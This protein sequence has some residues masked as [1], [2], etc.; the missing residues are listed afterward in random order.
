MSQ[1]NIKKW[2]KPGLYTTLDK[3]S[4]VLLGFINFFILSRILTKSDFGVWVLFTGL[5]SVLETLREG[6]IKQPFIAL[7]PTEGEDRDQIGSTALWL[8]W[9]YSIAVSLLLFFGGTYLELFWDAS[10]LGVLL[11]IYA[12]VNLI[13]VPFSHYEYLQQSMLDFKGI[14]I[15]HFSRSLIPTVFILV[16]IS[17]DNSLSLPKLA[18]SVLAGNLMGAIL[19][20]YWG[21]RYKHNLIRIAWSEVKT[22]LAFGR[23]SLGTNM[24]SLSI[25]NMDS[26]MLGKLL[27]TASVASYNPAIRIANLVE[28][29]TLTIANLVF[30][31]MAQH[32]RAQDVTQANELYSR[33]VGLLLT[34]MIPVSLVMFLF[35][36][37]IVYLIAGRNYLDSGYLLKIT[38]FYTLF[39]PFGRQFGILLDATRKPH[40]NFYVVLATAIVGSVT[41]Y[42]FILRWGVMGAAYGTLVTYL[43][44]FL[45]QQWWLYKNFKVSTLAVF[46]SVPGF[47]SYILNLILK[48]GIKK[49]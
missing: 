31:K 5:V 29:P 18:L 30:P 46:R 39:I 23:Y 43:T 20:M 24:A 21:W 16:M 10:P 34:L 17:L 38:A 15:S 12:V 11:K 32:H 6:F 25:R 37:Q 47:Y 19:M 2:I 33:S 45:F 41:T 27:T 40:I 36:D 4:V 49:K 35:S 7:M 28:I 9:I 14:F 44:R 13:F 26:W 3:F 8:N 42:L 48:N 22:M 1:F